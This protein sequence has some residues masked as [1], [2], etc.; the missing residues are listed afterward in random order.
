M[1]S[2]SNSFVKPTG[3]TPHAGTVYYAAGSAGSLESLSPGGNHP[4]MAT[5]LSQ[6]GS[7]VFETTPTTLTGSFLT[8]SGGVAD[9]FRITKR[10]GYMP[11]PRTC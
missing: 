10:P 4:V 8:S 6:M 9:S 11:P 7:V 5:T 1:S 3:F 2:S